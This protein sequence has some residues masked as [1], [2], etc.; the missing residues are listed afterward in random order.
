[1][2]CALSIEKTGPMHRVTMKD[3]SHLLLPMSAEDEPE[4]TELFDKVVAVRSDGDI[5]IAP[6]TDSVACSTNL[7]AVD[8]RTR[9]VR[10][11][12]DIWRE[13]GLLATAGTGGGGARL[14]IAADDKD[15]FVFSVT[16]FS[17]SLEVFNRRDG[18]VVF[19]FNTLYYLG[20]Y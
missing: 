18:A 20:D 19:R 15:V 14:F 17:V 12:S 3:G 6:Y 16:P 5:F 2:N 7:Y 9:A 1:M 11:T 10:W 4:L 8:S 13:G